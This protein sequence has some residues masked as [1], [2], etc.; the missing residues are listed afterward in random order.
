MKSGRDNYLKKPISFVL[1]LTL[2]FC[3]FFSSGT[4]FAEDVKPDDNIKLTVKADKTD[5]KDDELTNVTV[6]LSNDSDYILKYNSLDAVLSDYFELHDGRLSHYEET[7]GVG[8]SKSYSFTVEADADKHDDDHDK[9]KDK[10]K[11]ESDNKDKDSKDKDKS[12]SAAV[13]VRRNSNNPKTGS[14]ATGAFAAAIFLVAFAALILFLRKK[15]KASKALALILVLSLCGSFFAHFP[16]KANAQEIGNLLSVENSSPAVPDKDSQTPAHDYKAELPMTVNGVQTSITVNAHIGTFQHVDFPDKGE[17]IVTNADGYTLV[18]PLDGST[19]VDQ[20]ADLS[21]AKAHIILSEGAKGHEITAVSLSEDKK[22]LTI[23][24]K[25]KVKSG[26]EQ[27]TAD[28][29][30]GAIS[31]VAVDKQMTCKVTKP[32]P[33]IDTSHMDI[34][35]TEGENSKSTKTSNSELCLPVNLDSAQFTDAINNNDFTCL[36]ANAKAIKGAVITKVDIIAPDKAN[37]YVMMPGKTPAQIAGKM[38]GGFL[39]IGGKSINCDTLKLKFNLSDVGDTGVATAA[40]VKTGDD[41]K[42]KVTADKTDLKDDD[43]ATVTVTMANDSDYVLHYNTFDATLSD[44][45]EL[46]EGSLSHHEDTIG[47]GER[48]SYSFKVEVDDDK[49]DDDKDK[50]KDDDDDDDDNKKS[51]SNDKSK[52]K[53]VIVKTKNTGNPKTGGDPATGAIALAVFMI[54]AAA[55]ILFLR[56]KYKASKTLALILVVSLCGNFFVYFP[57]KA[58]AQ[59]TKNIIAEENADSG[60]S[61]KSDA[62]P[63]QDYKVVLPMTVD[64][65]KAT[66]TVKAHI[67]EIGEVGFPI[68]GQDIADTA[69][70]YKIKCQLEGGAFN[71]K[72]AD[73]AYAGSHITLSEGAEGHQISDATLSGDNQ[74]LILSINGKVKSGAGQIVADFE[75]GS[76]QNVA[77]DEQMTCNLTKPNPCIDADNIVISKGDDGKSTQLCLPV[78]IDSAQFTD[79]INN[80]DFTCEGSG[81]KN[82]NIT[83]VDV[84]DL[85]TANVY[86]NIP[87][88]SSSQIA[89]EIDGGTLKIDGKSINCDALSM[90]FTLPVYSAN[91]TSEIVG[92]PTITDNGD[93]TATINAVFK[94]SVN[95]LGNTQVN[96]TPESLTV[97]STDDG[98]AVSDITNVSGQ[99]FNVSMSTV[100]TLPDAVQKAA[101]AEVSE[102]PTSNTPTAQSDAESGTKPAGDTANS[103]QA[104]TSGDVQTDALSDKPVDTL[105][106]KQADVSNNKQTDASNNSQ[107]ETIDNKQAAT[108]SQAAADTEK[109]NNSD[110]ASTTATRKLLISDYEEI[111]NAMPANLNVS[112]KK[113]ALSTTSAVILKSDNLIPAV[114]G[115]K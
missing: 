105:N 107:A 19:F 23:F 95:A 81:F 12:K 106:D 111:I 101:D 65:E 9:D 112:I 13:I 113:S 22:T 4:V 26:A 100:V 66:I 114:V 62:K 86:V 28:F 46:A 71:D 70:D 30:A 108:T 21:F 102:T 49:H 5:L 37:I 103:K 3:M 104:D 94:E 56:K 1:F 47:I 44:S 25:G 98:M 16:M 82:A 17:D 91:I 48:K 63:A 41:V 24:I 35:K 97:N 14:P 75:S 11:D 76:I 83:K 53:P 67:G 58:K 43:Y 99:S 72:M 61:D 57:T 64:G 68:S 6:T 80:A 96:L 89:D 52:S 88:I 10:D 36:N 51:D 110:T 45:L 55:F 74:S 77:V 84:T 18:C 59:E 85:N 32:K 38:N 93:G 31:N 40:E 27:I 73:P 8:E 39:K 90:D 87:D 15:Y 60:T 2:V 54:A 69:E 7:I 92:T 50:D 29:K 79:A 20:M 78:N 34:V 33:F 42:L 115:M 109:S